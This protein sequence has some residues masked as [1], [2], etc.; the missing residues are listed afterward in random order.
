MVPK[1]LIPAN[2]NWNKVLKDLPEYDFEFRTGPHQSFKEGSQI[3]LNYGVR[4]N[5]KLLDTYG[6]CLHD[7]P[8]DF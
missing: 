3:F 2:T 7:N 5:S 8:F 6:F 4:D 1:K